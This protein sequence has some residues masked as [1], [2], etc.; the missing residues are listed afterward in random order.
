MQFPAPVLAVLAA[1]AVLVS[2]GTDDAPT[3]SVPD[4]PSPQPT[5]AVSQLEG[6]LL[7]VGDIQSIMGA[8]AMSP[9]TV[10]PGL[11]DFDVTPPEC[12]TAYTPGASTT[13]GG[14]GWIAARK[15]DLR[16]PDT[17]SHIAKQVVVSFVS[18]KAAKE[19]YT[20]AVDQWRSCARRSV[21]ER[22][23]DRL[24]SWTIGDVAEADGVATL[25]RYPAEANGWGCQHALTTMNN[26]A[27]D[28]L[29]CAYGVDDQGLRLARAIV[30]RSGGR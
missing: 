23:P 11:W 26:L 22:L 16:E 2:C 1:S 30:A 15:Q 3:K 10:K 14:T 25:P 20:R 7:P 27:V 5:V 21:T 29:A 18:A 24:S 19:F 17:V 8:P 13:Y 9:G 6:L 12:A 4:M 28:T